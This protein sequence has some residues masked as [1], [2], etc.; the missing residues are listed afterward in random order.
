MRVLNKKK[1]DLI[2]AT[3]IGFFLLF[4]SASLMYFVESEA[5]PDKFSNILDAMWWGIIPVTTVGYGDVY[6]ITPL[7]KLFGGII[8]FIGI[9]IIALP[10][11]IFSSG[12]EEEMR[13][14][15][16]TKECGCVEKAV[17]DCP[18]VGKYCPHTGVFIEDKIKDTK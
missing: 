15:Y 9:I 3:V 16:K 7:G 13:I 14:I 12:F 6:P 4:L 17:C 10:I 1:D 2:L 11:G 18:Y 8:T 5:Q